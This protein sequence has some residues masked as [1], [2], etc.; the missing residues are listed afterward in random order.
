MYGGE[1]PKTIGETTTGPINVG[2]KVVTAA[3]PVLRL[4]PIHR[5]GSR[6]FLGGKQI[7][8]YSTCSIYRGEGQVRRLRTDR[9]SPNCTSS[10]SP[11][12]LPLSASWLRAMGIAANRFITLLLTRSGTGRWIGVGYPTSFPKVLMLFTSFMTSLPRRHGVR[13][14]FFRLTPKAFGRTSRV[15][16]NCLRL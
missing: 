3:R 16:A 1:Q 5:Q 2:K 8:V 13:L 14:S 12:V 10:Q 6:R 7:C 11:S 15:S 9:L 4:S